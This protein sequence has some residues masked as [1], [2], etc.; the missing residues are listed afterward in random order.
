MALLKHT[1][2]KEEYSLAN[3]IFRKVGA[4]RC[5]IPGTWLVP[6]EPAEE[7]QKVSL[8]CRGVTYTSTRYQVLLYAFLVHT[9][10]ASL[11]YLY[12]SGSSSSIYG[13]NYTASN[14]NTSQVFH[15]CR[16]RSICVIMPLV[17]DKSSGAATA[18]LYY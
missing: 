15:V 6:T 18:L 4:L 11:Y 2:K 12:Y 16:V 17:T 13:I 8:P 3:N 5:Q 1:A 10:T 7:R 9:G 14:L